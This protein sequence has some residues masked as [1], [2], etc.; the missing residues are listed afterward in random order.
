MVVSEILLIVGAQFHQVVH[1]VGSSAAGGTVEALLGGG[2]V[3]MGVVVTVDGVLSLADEERLEGELVDGLEFGHAVE[4]DIAAAAHADALVQVRDR[5][6]IEIAVRLI[7]TLIGIIVD[8]DRLRRVLDAS[9]TVGISGIEA[10]IAVVLVGHD[11]RGEFQLV[12]EEVLGNLDT[13]ADVGAAGTLDG[14]LVVVVGQVGGIGVV[15]AATHDGEVVVMGDGGAADFLEPVG[16]VLAVLGNVTLAGPSF[17]PLGTQFVSGEEVR[18]P[19]PMGRGSV[20]IVLDRDRRLALGV[21]G[22]DDDDAVGTAGTVDGGGG[23]V[24]QD[25][26]GLNVLRGDR[27]KV[28]GD[29][30]H[31]HQRSR[32]TQEGRITAEHD[33]SGGRRVAGRERDLQT[34]HLALDQLACIQ[35]GTL[36]EI[37]RLHALDGGRDVGLLLG[38]V[39]DGHGFLKEGGRLFEDHVDD[40]AVP[41]GDGLGFIADAGELQHGGGTL[42]GNGVLTIHVGD[43]AVRRSCFHN[44]GRDDGFAVGTGDSTLDH[45]VGHC[46][47]GRGEQ[48]E[49]HTEM[50][51]QF[52]T[53][54]LLVIVLE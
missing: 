44:T 10:G 18:S 15:L 4:A 28:A 9:L 5:V 51:D 37:L 19:E 6:V 21:L 36:V 47:N 32:G 11:L 25:I 52:H 49:G 39:T 8:I 34:G 42:D 22:R 23:T 26:D 40:A 20:A 2:H 31:Q 41:D 33:G 1:Q 16:V 38:T 29:A 35:D 46:G 12:L 3:L 13:G 48:A 43:D 54:G 30:V 53:V 7:V 45:D 17:G 50:L 27:G 24:L 14:T